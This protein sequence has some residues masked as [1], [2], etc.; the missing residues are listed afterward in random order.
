MSERMSEQTTE[1]MSEQM[2]ESFVDIALLAFGG[3]ET[4][5]LV[6]QFL[7][8]MTGRT[9]EA[10]VVAAVS[11]RYEAIGGGSPLPAI[12]RRQ[13]AALQANLIQQL[14]FPLRVRAGFLYAD[15]SV[16]ECLGELDAHEVIAL[17]LSPYRSRLTSDAYRQALDA[18]GGAHVPMLEGWHAHPGYLRAV[19][20]R[21]AQALDGADAGDYAVLFTAH[22]V[23]AE[24]IH[25][26]DPYVE[27]LQETIARLV[28][29]ILPG[30]WRVG[31]QSKG[32]GGG[33]WLE[34]EAG[35]VVR[36]LAADGWRKLLVVPV[37]FVS[38]HVE[39]LYDLDVV[40]RGEAEAAGMQY[41][42]SR[43]PNDS[44]LF[45]EALA[46]VVVDYLARRPVEHQLH[47]PDGQHDHGGGRQSG[48]PPQTDGDKE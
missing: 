36:S 45:I 44:P 8:R 12:T 11:A 27:Q 3:P 15:P 25:E 16:A 29:S 26:G 42:R 24:T 1:G 4:T 31:F 19:S 17:P 40:L 28:P 20:E 6:P 2:R 18:A 23:P 35:D 33:Q 39:T 22:N 37:G 21:V 38:D 13:A 7:E 34:P 10:E 43:P 9:P 46:D 5:A 30:D 32:R 47:R 14:A 41:L 48:S